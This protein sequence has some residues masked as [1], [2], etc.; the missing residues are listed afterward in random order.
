V[1]NDNLEPASN[2]QPLN[3]KYFS[4]ATERLYTS[5]GIEQEIT[6][7]LQRKANYTVTTIVRTQG[8]TGISEVSVTVWY[9]GKNGHEEFRSIAKCVLILV[10]HLYKFN[11]K[12]ADFVQIICLL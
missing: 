10:C 8:S 3:G 5:N 9:K 1:R 11:L 2:I 6:S 7:K 4:V 12:R